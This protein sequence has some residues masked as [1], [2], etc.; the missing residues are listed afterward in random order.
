M[1][2]LTEWKASFGRAVLVFLEMILKSVQRVSELISRPLRRRVS[3]VLPT[4]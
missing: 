4:N 2:T 3:G 1:E